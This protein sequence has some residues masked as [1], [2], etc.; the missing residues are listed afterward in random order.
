MIGEKLETQYNWSKLYPDA[1]KKLPLDVPSPLRNDVET[2]RSVSGVLV[3]LNSTP[4]KWHS[5]RQ[6]TVE[7]ST[8]SSE[9]TALKVAVEMTIELRY[10]LRMLGV[11]IGGPTE[12]LG[13]NR[14]VAMNVSKPES[15][16]KKKSNLC[17]YH[18][19]REAS[20]CSIATYRII[21]SKQNF[22]DRLT[23]ALAPNVLSDLIKPWL[24]R[25]DL[26]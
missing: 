25:N 4:I 24:F 12:M 26:G 13:D 22:A 3:F 7:T 5:K 20:A 14:S 15:M 6:H 2:R 21:T 11:L 23:K 9:M 1:E 19:C 10:N 18:Y 16:L 17:S 8:Y